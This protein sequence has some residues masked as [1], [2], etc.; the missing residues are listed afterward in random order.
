MQ[1]KKREQAKGLASNRP[2]SR[3]ESVLNEGGIRV[4]SFQWDFAV[5]GG[6]IASYASGRKLPAGSVVTRVWS[7]EET[8]T[9]PNSPALTATDID[10]LAGATAL[11]SAVDFTADAGFQARALDGSADG[12]KLAAESELTMAINTPAATAGKIRWFVEY[13]LPND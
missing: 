12:I 7:D 1:A 8:A 2:N 4:A 3:E 9:G 10:L 13:I 5:D 6:A 11:V